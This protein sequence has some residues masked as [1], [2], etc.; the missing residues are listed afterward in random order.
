MT[1]RSL[2]KFKAS[3]RWWRIDA[4]TWTT[5]RMVA[6]IGTEITRSKRNPLGRFVAFA[7]TNTGHYRAEYLPTSQTTINPFHQ[8]RKALAD[9]LAV[10]YGYPDLRVA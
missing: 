3:G 6:G 1:K 10:S 2:E 5:D 4:L 8:P 7:K 9:W